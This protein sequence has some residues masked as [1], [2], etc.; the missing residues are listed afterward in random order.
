MFKFIG[1]PEAPKQIQG[2]CSRKPKG[3]PQ[4]STEIHRSNQVVQ[5]EPLG[6]VMG[7]S[8]EDHKEI[9]KEF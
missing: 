8:L 9:D 5:R 3:N 7:N 4:K 6:S 2:Q 1:N